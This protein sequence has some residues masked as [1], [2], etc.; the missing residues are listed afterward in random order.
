MSWIT[1]TAQWLTL[2]AA[3]T[4]MVM[5]LVMG[6]LG[7]DQA[8]CGTPSP[9]GNGMAVMYLLMAGFHAAPWL[10]LFAHK[11]AHTDEGLRP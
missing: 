2:A 10:R 9:H 8:I 7:G 6:A 4:F 11:G 5:A 3:P 1:R